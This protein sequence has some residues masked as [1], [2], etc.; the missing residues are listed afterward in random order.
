MQA[1]INK[2][3]KRAVYLARKAAGQTFPNP[4][5]G[6]VIVNNGRVVGE[7]FHRK[8]G[9]P[10]AE[11]FA[12][13]QAK[14][15][16]R[17]AIL[18]CTFEPCAHTGRTG[19]CVNEVIKSGISRVYIG[20]KDPNPLTGGKGMAALRRAGVRVQMGFLEKEIKSLNEPFFKA[21]QKKMPFVTIKIAQSLDGKIATSGG[22]SK[23]ITNKTSRAAAHQARKFYDCIIAGSGTVLADDPR[24]ESLKGNRLIKVL[25]DS[26]MRIPLSARCFKTR[27][28]VVVAAVKRNKEK[29]EALKKAGVRVFYT[30]PKK[31]R[32]DLKK[33]LQYLGSFEIRNILVEGGATLIG[34]FLDERLADKAVLFIAPRIIG[35]ARS[36]SSVA[37]VGAIRLRESIFLKNM[38]LKK[39]Q[40]DIFIEG[41][42]KY[43]KHAG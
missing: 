30:K 14:E 42:L 21:F 17:G 41:Y 43:P 12:L 35:G 40:D 31:G 6:A 7:G 37:G 26:Q 8:A 16:S 38:T 23:W 29:E 25:V 10:H 36:K 32:V 9:G 15:K 3:M 1:E 19:P 18:F 20:T 2:Y 33:L 28:P 11:I 13:R 5:V 34:S 24:L 4:L 27:Q 22:E 39:I